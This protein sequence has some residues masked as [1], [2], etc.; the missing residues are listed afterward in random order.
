MTIYNLGSINADLVYRVPHLPGPGETL[1]ATSRSTGLGGKGANMSVAA[2]RAGARVVHLGAVGEE[3]GWMV[4]RL[5][6]YGV[7][8]GHVAVAAEA[9]GHAVIAVDDAGENLILIH[10]G[11][12]RA[13]SE[14]EIALALEGAG[15]GDSFLFQNETNA[16]AAGAR[17]ARARGLRVIHAAAPFEAGAVRAVLDLVD[18]LVLNEVEAAQLEAATGRALADLPVAE[19]VVT[20][21]ARG[22][23]WI[24]TRTGAVHEVAARKV[25]PVDTTG[26]GDTFTGYLAAALDRGAGLAAALDLASRAA[27]LMVTRPG[28]ADAIPSLAE[29]EAEGRA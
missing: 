1:A 22:C 29:V 25:T 26:A 8:T 19:I 3:G 14:D 5:A 27:A 10:P 18:L 12:N 7:E 6:A 4:E 23:R 2:A 9:S 15:P 28:A 11:A 21:G 13:I 16:Q 24:S 17:A 20:L